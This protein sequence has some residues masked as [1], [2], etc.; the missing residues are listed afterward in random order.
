MIEPSL[1]GIA[2][3]AAGA[4]AGALI[5]AATGFGFAIIAAPVF[6]GVLESTTAI[7]ILIALHIVQC[8]MVVPPAWSRAPR[9]ELGR[10]VIGAAA[11][12]P[13]GFLLLGHLD[14]RQLKLAAGSVI[15]IAAALIAARRLLPP[16]AAIPAT[17]DGGARR[18]A[19]IATGAA[20][21]ALTAL[22]VMPGPPLMIHLM[23]R[24]VAPDEAR[25]LALTFFAVC[26]VAVLGLSLAAGKLGVAEWRLIGLLALPVV[27]GTVMG[28]GLA[29]ALADRYFAPVLNVL[30]V[31][32]GLGALLSAL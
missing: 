3:L 22:L 16:P 21:G 18:G 2:S 5:Q 13:L 19:A 32:A 14:V 31:L 29:R 20:A 7:P 27:V 8:V 6:L 11:G 10:L 17:Q 9:R 12:A 15:L 28:R 4:A 24:P 1:A 23:C 30:L 25:S 26:Y